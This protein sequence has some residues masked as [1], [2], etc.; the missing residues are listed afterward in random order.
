[1]LY[2]FK[3]NSRMLISVLIGAL[4]SFSFNGSLASGLFSKPFGHGAVQKKFNHPICTNG[5]VRA[6]LLSPNGRTL[7]IGGNFTQ[8][9]KCSG[10]GVSLN[11]STGLKPESFD[12]RASGVVGSVSAA[13][14]D[15]AGG[16]YIGGSFTTIGK[17]S[18]INLARIT[19]ANHVDLTFNPP[20]LDGSVSAL[21]L[22]G[23][24][25]Y[26]G[27]SFTYVGLTARPNLAKLNSSTGSLISAFDAG[28]DNSVTSFEYDGSNLYLGGSFTIVNS[29]YAGS[30]GAQIDTATSI[31]NT[32]F[33]RVNGSIAAVISDGAGGWYI[34]GSFTKVGTEIRNYLAQIDSLGN[35]TSF[36]PNMN[37]S[38]LALAISGT[39]LYAGGWFS[40]VNGSTARN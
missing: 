40:T 26:V 32:S 37:S 15:G 17:T 10:G 35:V 5:D 13:I 3:K 19:S 12:W 39:T 34:G 33:P 16:W 38:V 30:R 9:A 6:T 29:P 27:G 28:L 36:N 18:R 11:T 8:I 22:I 4:M 7:Y 1:M 24:D 20:E 21:R 2:N 14:S 31:A 23:S 25:L